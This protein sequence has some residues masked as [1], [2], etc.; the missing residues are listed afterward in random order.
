MHVVNLVVKVILYCFDDVKMCASKG[1]QGNDTVG[2][3]P[4][5]DKDL[6]E[7]ALVN[8]M[9]DADKEEKEM[10]EGDEEDDIEFEGDLMEV[11]MA[12]R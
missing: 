8:L 9:K 2:N 4:L 5:E 6:D 10:D 7:V 3:K 1:D 12:I 11:E